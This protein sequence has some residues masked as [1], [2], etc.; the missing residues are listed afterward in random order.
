[1]Y[2]VWNSRLSRSLV[3]VLLALAS[4]VRPFFPHTLFLLAILETREEFAVPRLQPVLHCIC[5]YETKDHAWHTNE[6]FPVTLLTGSVLKAFLLFSFVYGALNDKP[7]VAKRRQPVHVHVTAMRNYYVS[8]D[9]NPSSSTPFA[10]SLFLPSPPL[11][12]FHLACAV[13]R[14]CLPLPPTFTCAFT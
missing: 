13:Y 10:F 12:H 14:Y 9:Q 8:A 5:K 7:N 2:T 6:R 1:V 4:L 11:A 3:R